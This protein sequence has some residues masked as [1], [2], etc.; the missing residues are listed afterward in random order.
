[1]GSTPTQTCTLNGEEK[2]NCV[3]PRC[4][5]SNRRPCDQLLLPGHTGLSGH[6]A[7]YPLDPESQQTLPKLLLADILLQV[8]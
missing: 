7:L 6:C 1:M 3:H 4:Q 2:A 8:R 5:L